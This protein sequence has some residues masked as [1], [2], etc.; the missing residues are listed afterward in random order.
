MNLFSLNFLQMVVFLQEAVGNN[1]DI[2]M[3]TVIHVK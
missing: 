3:D 1:A 2:Y